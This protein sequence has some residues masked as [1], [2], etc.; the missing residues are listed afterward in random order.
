MAF[1]RNLLNDPDL[2]VPYPLIAADLGGIAWGAD[3]QTQSVRVAAS[4]DSY[5]TSYWR[6][7]PTAAMLQSTPPLSEGDRARFTMDLTLD[8]PSAGKVTALSEQLTV[9]KASDL[10]LI[11][12]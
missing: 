12:I 8:G 2:A 4:P 9:G 7:E 1:A 10:S 11:H 3:N 6:L 5:T